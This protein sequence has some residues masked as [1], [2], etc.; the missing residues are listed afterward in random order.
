MLYAASDKQGVSETQYQLK[1]SR[2][3]MTAGKRRAKD[4][5]ISFAEYLRELMVRDIMG[6]RRDEQQN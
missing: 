4:Q 1:A 6:A 3:L 2:E 5:Q